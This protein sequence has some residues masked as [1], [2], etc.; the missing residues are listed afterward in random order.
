[1]YLLA[2]HSLCWRTCKC[3]RSLQHWAPYAHQTRPQRIVARPGASLSFAGSS[4]SGEVAG[5]CVSTM[6][7]MHNVNLVCR[8]SF[9]TVQSWNKH[10]NTLRFLSPAMAS[11]NLG[12]GS[13]SIMAHANS[14]QL[15]PVADSLAV[16][17]ASTS[18]TMSC[19]NALSTVSLYAMKSTSHEL[20][21]G[22]SELTWLQPHANAIVALMKGLL[23]CTPFNI[24]INI[25][26]P[27]NINSV[28]SWDV[29]RPFLG[30]CRCSACPCSALKNGSMPICTRNGPHY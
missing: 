8:A 27:T 5:F 30:G 23:T 7:L 1:M 12:L 10:L 11:T 22:S 2:W 13:N 26:H 24:N 28:W 16:R 4:S 19:L 20:R 3:P 14:E 6:L 21:V 25:N 17:C 15:C 18:S 29:S 9:A